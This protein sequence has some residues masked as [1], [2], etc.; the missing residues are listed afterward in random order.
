MV[1]LA[2]VYMA[3]RPALRSWLLEHGENS[4]GIWVIYRKGPDRTISYDDIVEEA[5]CF[6]W[7]DS[8]PRKRDDTHA[9]LRLTPRKRTSGWSK[10]NKDRVVSLRERGLMRPAGEAAIAAA[11]ANGAWTSL[12]EAHSLREPQ[13]LTVALTADPDASAN[14]GRFPPSARK[15]ILEWLASAKTEATRSSRISKIVSE[16]HENRRANQWRQPGAS[17]AR[18]RPPE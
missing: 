5:L 12:D 2:Q 9:M 1:E 16:A 17:T 10:L 8:Q 13:D 6:G 18:A 4:P 7:V 14:W 3:D 15:A 11:Q